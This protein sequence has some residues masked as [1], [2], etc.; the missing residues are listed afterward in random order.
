[1]RFLLFAAL[2]SNLAGHV[3]AQTNVKVKPE[4]D[5]ITRYSFSE[6]IE[7]TAGVS[8]GYYYLLLDR[9]YHLPK[10]QFYRHYVTKVLSENGLTEVSAISESYDPSYQS[11]VFHKILVHRQGKTIDKLAKAKFEILR[12]EENLQRLVYDKGM[13]A[14]LNLEDIRVGDVVEY[15]YTIHGNNPVFGTHYFNTFHLNY[16]LPIGKVVFTLTAEKSRKLQFRYSGTQMPS[17]SESGD[18]TTYTWE[19]DNV[20]PQLMED[21]TPSWYDAFAHVQLTDFASWEELK[22]WGNELYQIREKSSAEIAQQLVEINR[23]NTTQDEKILAAIRFVQG[24]IRYLS[25][26]DG[27]HSHKPHAPNQVMAKKF[28]DCKDKSVLLSH[29]LNKMGVESYP[30]FV[31]TDNG[32]MLPETLPNPWAFNHCIVQFTFQDSV[33]WVDPTLSPQ[34]GKLKTLDFPHYRHALVLDNKQTGLTPIPFG[35]HESR[36]NVSEEYFVNDVGTSATLKVKSEFYGDEAEEIR[37]YKNSNSRAEINQNYLNFYANDFPDIVRSKDVEFSDDK[38]NNIITSTE[39]Y[40]IKDF[41]NYES[42]KNEYSQ[43]I[44]ARYLATYLSKPTTKIRKMPL[45]ISYPREVHHAIKMHMSEPWDINETSNE[46]ECASFKYHSET[47]YWDNT[48]S[49]RFSYV[50]K[51]DFIEADSVRDHIA[52]T[53]A[54]NEDLNYHISYTTTPATTTTFNYPYVLLTLV[55]G[56]VLYQI[57]LRLYYYDPAPLSE[58]TEFNEIGGWL[59]LLCFGLFLTPVISVVS[60]V[61][62]EYFNYHNWRIFMEPAYADYNPLLGLFVLVEYLLQLT[63]LGFSIVILLLFIRRRSSIPRLLSLMY[64]FNIVL[65]LSNMM[66]GRYFDLYSDGDNSD[67]SYEIVRGFFAACIW[68]PYLFFSDRSKGTFTVRV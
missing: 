15:A 9:Q 52:K 17:T 42:V 32:K 34:A 60:I 28:G 8:N 7:D 5:W 64:I 59:M 36:I 1:M 45:R 65:I 47:K 54:V 40:F 13:S 2:L 26:S 48:I 33:Y 53:D 30:A 29:M 51:T 21:A 24:D 41:W 12:R 39:E 67:S 56:W 31:S 68:I 4:P 22:K 11:L 66:A 19:S 43:T 44:Y 58:E 27:I 14:V 49:L 57:G 61:R 38:V 37:S 16:S 55:F 18:L 6:H 50:T 62:N 25:F 23:A 3:L 63:F 10:K 35:I 46:I 20:P